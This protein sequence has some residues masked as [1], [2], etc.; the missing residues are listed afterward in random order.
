M[1]FLLVLHHDLR[2]LEHTVESHEQVVVLLHIIL[3][4]EAWKTN[5][6]R[7]RQSM[8]GKNGRSGSER[9]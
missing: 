5:H 3:S 8:L 7:T 1:P 2:L 4:H 9:P 6:T